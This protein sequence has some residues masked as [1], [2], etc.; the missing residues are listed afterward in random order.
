MKI[1]LYT[2]SLQE[3]HAPS[4]AVDNA[5][6]Y[7]YS[8]VRSETR[9]TIPFKRLAI[10]ASIVIIAVG[11]WA[12][13][14]MF[15]MPTSVITLD[16]RE[17]V[18]ITLNSR[19]NILSADSYSEL[20]GKSA[21]S[22][23]SAITED[24][25][26][27]NVLS[28]DENTVLVGISGTAQQNAAQIADSIT[29]TF[30]AHHFDGCCITVIGEDADP[31]LSLIRTMEDDDP[32]L[33]GEELRKLSVNDLCLLMLNSG[34]RSDTV[35]VSGTPSESAYIGFDGAVAKALTLSNLTQEELVDL[36]VSYSIY[37]GRLIYLVRL[38][39]GDT[40]EAYFIN[41]V[42]GATEQAIKA[43]SD[44]IGQEIEKAIDRSH[45]A[46]DP[47]TA[48][49]AP[50]VVDATEAVDATSS[51][52]SPNMPPLEEPTDNRPDDSSTIPTIPII[53]TE[54]PT[55][56]YSDKYRSTP[57]TLTQ[58]SF[59]TLSPPDTAAEVGYKTLFEGQYIEPRS[60]DKVNGGAV[61]VITDRGQLQQ[62]F[63]DNHLR[64][65]DKN[66]G[67]LTNDFTDEYFKTRY[68]I[69]S[70]CTVSDASYYTTITDLKSDGDMIYMEN[71]L[72]YGASK[73]GEYLCHTLSLYELNRS[74]ASPDQQLT[75]Y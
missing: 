14:G 24:M 17:S 3:I 16:S 44:K 42:S 50:V 59:V 25:L 20:S 22:S 6:R 57:V 28:E 74:A 61:A 66:G 8:G 70:T 51:T 37:H 23:V 64:Y 12:I 13:Y 75:V 2:K 31:K 4:S 27:R 52:D 18:T 15:I 39:A 54:L 26:N 10:A 67:S 71:S 19:G 63:S 40:G 47:T 56:S 1:N 21:S 72:T 73:S 33:S 60:G 5:L 9:R 62:F 11:I 53:P 58:L 36:S 68:L 55:T 69:A 29:D 7:A 35:L 41:A 43:P 38:N 45:T 30:D 34:V 32:A 46:A 65:T 48:T 49:Q